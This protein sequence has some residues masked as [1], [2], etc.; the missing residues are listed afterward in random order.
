MFSIKSFYFV[1]RETAIVDQMLA[2]SHEPSQD[3]VLHFRLVARITTKISF[4]MKQKNK[5]QTSLNRNEFENILSDI[6]AECG[7]CGQFTK[8]SANSVPIAAGDLSQTQWP[9]VFHHQ[10]T[11]WFYITRH[12]S[13]LFRD[14]ILMENKPVALKMTSSEY[15]SLRRTTGTIWLN[16]VDAGMMA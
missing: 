14:L 5:F 2:L 10:P 4:E 15:P 6:N 9:P 12:S 3:F 7:N 13:Y 11:C 1:E 16:N 8:N